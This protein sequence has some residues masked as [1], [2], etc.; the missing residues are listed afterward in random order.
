MYQTNRTLNSYVLTCNSEL[1]SQNAHFLKK[2]SI[3]NV[4]FYFHGMQMTKL[5]KAITKKEE[6]Q[7]KQ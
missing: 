6:Q 2:N 7:E 1:A 5:S 3:R 4:F